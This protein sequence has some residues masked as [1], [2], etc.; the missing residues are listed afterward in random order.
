MAPL[1]GRGRGSNVDPDRNHCRPCT[2]TL[3]IAHTHLIEYEKKDTQ[4]ITALLNMGF[5]RDG[6][7]PRVEF[8]DKGKRTIRRFRAFSPLVI[9]GID[10][11]QIPLKSGEFSFL[12]SRS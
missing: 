7:V 10:K 4:D 11:Q 6:T 1:R 8:D 5:M 12:F 9:A 3:W 2:H